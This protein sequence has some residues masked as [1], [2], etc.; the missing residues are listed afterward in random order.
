MRWMLGTFEAGLYPG[1]MYYLSWCVA[2]RPSV[3]SP[4]TGRVQLVQTRRVWRPCSGL[5]LRGDNLGR[6]RWPSRR[7]SV[8]SSFYRVS[9]RAPLPFPRS[10]AAISKMDGIGGK[11]GW[12]WIFII[13]GLA[14]VLAGSVSYWIIVD[15]PE[16]AKFLTEQEQTFVIRR[17]QGDD[18]FSA[19]GEKLRWK[20]V[21]ESLTEWKT[22]LCSACPS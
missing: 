17:L 2:L 14:T 9:H 5:L 4:L 18:Q 16:D 13:E 15:F 19:A 20:N 6:L 10:Q 1:V 21:V 8:S 12:A 3:Q 22:Y 11:P 7:E